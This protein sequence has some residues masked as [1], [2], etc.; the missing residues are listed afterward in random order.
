MEY[1]NAGILGYM[2]SIPLKKVNFLFGNAMIAMKVSLS[3]DPIK[4]FMEKSS[5]LIPKPLRQIQKSFGF[6]H[7]SIVPP[8]HHSMGVAPLKRPL[9]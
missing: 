7:S 8:F 5:K 9:E 4:K 1:W 6:D 3:P 2:H